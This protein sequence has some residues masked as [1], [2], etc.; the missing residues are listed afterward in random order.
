MSQA[1][2]KGIESGSCAHLR[3]LALIAFSVVSISAAQA[4]DEDPIRID[5]D[6]WKPS[7]H[8]IE[9]SDRTARLAPPPLSAPTT[10]T[11]SKNAALSQQIATPSAPDVTLPVMPGVNQGFNV[12]VDSTA[13]DESPTTT[14]P[15]ET[16]SDPR[17][18]DANWLAPSSLPNDQMQSS[19]D[20]IAP[21]VK[22]R[23]TFLPSSLPV[24]KKTEHKSALEIGRAQM[25]QNAAIEAEK[26]AA[27]KNKTPAEASACAALDAIKKQQIDAI[28]GDRRTLQALQDAIRS[29]GLSKQLDFSSGTGSI[30]AAEQAPANSDAPKTSLR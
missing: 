21:P 1:T 23:M 15:Q 6:D 9:E 30:S 26:A 28:Q 10:N 18:S 14:S 17:L 27:A 22:V 25:K 4:A 29:L 2:K 7:A 5:P 19:A 12:Q 11:A 3:G 16:E 8:F 24:P 13:K 20:G